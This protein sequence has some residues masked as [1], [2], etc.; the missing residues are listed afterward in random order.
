[1]PGK[2][3]GVRSIPEI[4]SRYPLWE[5]PNFERDVDEGRFYLPDA[6]EG[7]RET[8]VT[9]P[10]DARP[11]ACLRL[12][13]P[14]FIPLLASIATGGFFVLGTFHLWWPACLSLVAAMAIIIYWLWTGTAIIPEKPEKDVGLGLRLPLYVSGPSSVS[15]W[16]MFITMLAVLTAFVCIVFAYF[17]FWTAHDDFPP[18]PSPGPGVF[19]PTLGG[20]L[21]VAAWALTLFARGRNRADAVRSFYAG[22]VGA[23]LLA[24][25]GGAA[26][27]AGPFLSGLDPTHHVYQAT[28]WLLLIWS[29]GHVVLGIIMQLYCAARRLAGRMTAAYDADMANVALYWHFCTVTTVIT[30]A[31][32]AGFPLVA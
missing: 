18:N 26:L 27:L 1:M 2:P 28:V 10:I 7:K 17:F 31:V 12:P 4:D 11:E 30:V 5:Q 14:S 9:S 19:W 6:E 20:L 22:L 3:W 8:I 25:A 23:V 13:G 24:A 29:A 21:V 15:W 16:A 32:I